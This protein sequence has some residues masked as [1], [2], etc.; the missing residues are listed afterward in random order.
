MQTQTCSRFSTG[1][2]VYY[3]VSVGGIRKSTLPLSIFNYFFIMYIEGKCKNYTV[4]AKGTFTEWIALC[5]QHKIIK[6]THPTPCTPTRPVPF[7][8]LHSHPQGTYLTTT[9]IFNSCYH[10]QV[11]ELYIKGITYLSSFCLL[12]NIFVRFIHIGSNWIIGLV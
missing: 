2:K 7:Q 12:N 3:A 6:S 5:S 4:T 8:A 10:M 1:N 9:C 11:F